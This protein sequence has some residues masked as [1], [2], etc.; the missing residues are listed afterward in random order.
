MCI[1]STTL[2]CRYHL[3]RARPPA[4][5]ASLAHR[6]LLPPP[7]YFLRLLM[8]RA[9]SSCKRGLKSKR[10]LQS[11]RGLKRV[12]NIVLWRVPPQKN[13]RT[14]SFANINRNVNQSGSYLVLRDQ[15]CSCSKYLPSIKWP[16][17]TRAP[18]RSSTSSHSLCM[19]LVCSRWYW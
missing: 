16:A 1:H 6:L 19:P 15:D 18:G 8:R 13:N 17:F 12:V 5:R 11:K 14:N 10:G 9:P 7:Y 3:P 2:T 4:L